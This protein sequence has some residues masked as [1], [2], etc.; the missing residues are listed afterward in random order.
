MFECIFI[1]RRGVKNLDFSFLMIPS[2]L[3]RKKTRKNEFDIN[4]DWY[5]FRYI[6]SVNELIKTQLSG[7]LH[8]GLL[9]DYRLIYRLCTIRTNYRD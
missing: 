3:R 2:S 1:V 7:Y 9:F 4:L 8:N 6:Q 5:K